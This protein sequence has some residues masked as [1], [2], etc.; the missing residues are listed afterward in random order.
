MR[1]IKDIVAKNWLLLLILIAAIYLRFYRIGEFATFLAD[2]GRDAII[3]KRIATLEH[4][5]AIGAPTSVGQVFL[6]PFYYYFISPW[7]LLFNFDP[8]GLAIGMAVTSVVFLILL[9]S[10]VK[11]L[12]DQKAALIS[13]F[14]ASFSYVF[15]EASRFSWNPNPLPLFS[16]LTAFSFI[17]ANKTRKPLYFLLFGGFLALSIQLHYLATALALPLVVLG[18]VD[19]Y[20]NRSKLVKELVNYLMAIG[21]F[22]VFMSPLIIFDLRHDFININSLFKL[23]QSG[24]GVG[25]GKWTEFINT[26][27]DVNRYLFNVDFSSL[28]ATVMFIIIALI[29]I[30]SIIKKK[31]LISVF[32]VFFLGTLAVA[33][34]YPGVKHVHY[35]GMIYPFYIVTI[36][37]ILSEISTH[38]LLDKSLV[39]LFLAA[40]LYTNFQKYSF[41]RAEPNNQ[42]LHAKKVAE[43][44]DKKITSKK[45][46][47]AVQPDGWQEDSYLYFLE[48][49]G[50]V[51]QDRA[52]FEV[53]DE[54]FVVCGNPCNIKKTKSWN[55]T[56][57]GPSKI[58]NEWE[59]EG[60]K[61]YRLVHEK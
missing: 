37:A 39:V 60:V 30:F 35:L 57:F 54:M 13:V 55:I 29:L 11:K 32:L 36:A 53:G 47:F 41:L 6:G 4:L 40:F 44:I 1:R 49:K 58:S 22:V 48:L 45:F 7:I 3:I 9:Y 59:T 21:S 27:S 20:I 31:Q 61:I 50:K 2:Q 42:I 43:F 24:S 52:K 23:L 17:M 19:I 46:N 8:A 56:M 38:E 15:I 33:S 34:L 25:G 16:L 26:F 18:L 28:T 14:M 12:F 51:P 10:I 5:P